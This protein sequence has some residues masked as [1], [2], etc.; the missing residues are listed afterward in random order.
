MSDDRWADPSEGPTPEELE[1]ERA[2]RMLDGHRLRNR[3]TFRDVHSSV[4]ADDIEAGI[5]KYCREMGIPRGKRP[6][7]VKP[8]EPAP[9]EAAAKPS[10]SMPTDEDWARLERGE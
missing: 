9:A 1:A 8:C 4:S 7:R 10:A 2:R 6:E 3:P 5:E